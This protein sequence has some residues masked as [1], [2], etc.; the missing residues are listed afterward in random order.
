MACDR[1]CGGCPFD[2]GAEETELT[3][4]YGCLPT[5]HEIMNMRVHH[6]KTW[7]CHSDPTTPC[8]GA[9]Q[10]LKGKGHPYKVEDRDLLTE[11]SPWH[12][13]VNRAATP[14]TGA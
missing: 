2:F 11:A 12:L 10:F 3:Q 14:G 8:V 4:N 13:Y 1:L 9:I 5:P 6:G 7:A